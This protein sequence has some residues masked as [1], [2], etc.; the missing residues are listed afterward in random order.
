MVNV[1]APLLFNLNNTNNK[2][3]R[4]SRLRTRSPQPSLDTE[5]QS[6]V[7]SASASASGLHELE[8]EMRRPML[9]VRIVR[10]GSALA[11][12]RPITRDLAVSEPETAE[13]G[14]GATGADTGTVEQ[15]VEAV[16]PRPS[17]VRIEPSITGYLSLATLLIWVP[18]PM[19]LD[20]LMKAHGRLGCPVRLLKSKTWGRSPGAGA[21]RMEYDQTMGMRPHFFF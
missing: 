20:R 3:P 7:S 11:R 1:T 4:L 9:N 15:P 14:E 5:H 16:A 10:S 17:G 13:E 2:R 19:T 12:G 21:T 18:V 6:V 8:E